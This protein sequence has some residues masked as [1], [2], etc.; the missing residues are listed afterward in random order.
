MNEATMSIYMYHIIKCN[1]NTAMWHI[2][3]RKRLFSGGLFNQI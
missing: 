3:K 2:F 1:H